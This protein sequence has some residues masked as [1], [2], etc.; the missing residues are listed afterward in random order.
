MVFV[1]HNYYLNTFDRH[2]ANRMGGLGYWGGG[3]QST[4]TRTSIYT[5]VDYVSS[6]CPQNAQ[7]SDYYG[8]IWLCATMVQI[9][10]VAHEY[11]HAVAARDY[12]G[13]VYSGE[14]GA[15]EEGF[16]DV[17]GTAVEKYEYGVND[18][19]FATDTWFPRS[20][21][22]PPSI[23]HVTR[24]P[25]PDRK[26]SPYYWCAS[27]DN[28]GVHHNATLVGKASYL[29]SE[30][31]EFNGCYFESFGFD[32][33][34]QIFYR[35]YSTYMV[36]TSG[37][38]QLMTALQQAC[39]DRYG[40]SHPEYLNT[41]T[42]VLQAVEMDQPGRCSGTPEVA[43][44]S[45][46]HAAGVVTCNPVWSAGT[47][48]TV[49]G[50]GGMPGRTVT[51]RLVSQPAVDTLWAPITT[52]RSETGQIQG[53][54]TLLIIWLADTIGTFDVI[55]DENSDEFYQP[56]ADTILSI[57]I[58]G[59]GV[60]GRCCY[61]Y[62][63]AC[64]DNATLEQCMSLSGDWDPVSNCV[65]NPCLPFCWSQTYGGLG[66]DVGNAIV[67]TEDCGFVIAGYTDTPSDSSDGWIV[68]TDVT[69][70][71]L[72]SRTIGGIGADG[73][74][75]VVLM[76]GGDVVACGYKHNLGEGVKTDGL[77]DYRLMAT[78]FGARLLEER[79][80]MSSMMSR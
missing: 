14:S 31:T 51:A 65:S 43:P 26:C 32:T 42:K 76:P 46:I 54:G 53:D 4:R 19:I 38:Q 17:M 60:T 35:A 59:S 45:A 36:S 33:T 29:M 44:A 34:Q 24:G 74:N 20:M 61:Q 68:R 72:W 6:M 23:P 50:T 40:V 2:G 55:V 77:S 39:T 69:G 80:G 21:A 67:Q 15:T 70:S 9:E 28:Y 79:V 13:S 12:H 37:F 58:N 8:D 63:L 66:H 57:T 1:I 25:F 3:A 41:V 48:I 30:G 18:W 47:M 56:W 10:I 73:F 16:C 22:D 75:D 7:Y 64:L 71:E 11:A 52:L 27:G 5:F 62:G 78:H 49:T